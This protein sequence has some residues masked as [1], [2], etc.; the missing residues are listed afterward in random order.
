MELLEGNYLAEVAVP[1]TEVIFYI[2]ELYEGLEITHACMTS[3]AGH[4]MDLIGYTAD[5]RFVVLEIPLDTAIGSVIEY[6]LSNHLS[7]S[8]SDMLSNNGCDESEYET[9]VLTVIE[10]DF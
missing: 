7:C 3:A 10:R 6:K 8:E 1:G 9:V 5:H 4:C 2:N